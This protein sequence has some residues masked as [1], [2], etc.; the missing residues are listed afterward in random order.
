M[1]QDKLRPA[2]QCLVSACRGCPENF[3]QYPLSRNFVFPAPPS[4][5]LQTL[6]F[7]SWFLL[8]RQCYSSV[9]RDTITVDVPFDPSDN[10]FSARACTFENDADLSSENFQDFRQTHHQC[11]FRVSRVSQLNRP[12]VTAFFHF[13]HLFTAEIV[14]N[15][16]RLRRVR[17][18]AIRNAAMTIEKRTII[19]R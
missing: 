15:A 2:V 9:H 12:H 19:S 18:C 1:G 6:V 11:A 4:P 14:I 16:S 5:H 8:F 17:G 13:R 3:F 10:W 7:S